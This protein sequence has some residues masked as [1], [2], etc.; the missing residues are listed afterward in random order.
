MAIVRCLLL[1]A[2]WL[3]AAAVPAAGQQ[4]VDYASVSGR[5]TDPSGAVV[6]GARVTA[7]HLGTNIVSE[8][9]TDATGRFRFPHLRIGRCDITVH[10]PGFADAVRALTLTAG[11]AFELPLTLTVGGLDASVTVSREA[12]VLDS[13]RSQ[14][15]GTISQ[16]EVRALPLDGRNFLDLAL[17]VPGAAPANV[18]ATQLF[19]E[20]SAVPGT[21]LSIGGQRNLSTSFIVDGMSANDD[22]AALSGIPYSVDAIE[23]L[24]VVTSGGQA[25]L[26]RALGGYVS[27]VTRSGSNTLTGDVYGYARDERLNARNALSGSR[28]PMRQVQYG[29]SLGGPLVASRTFY[30]TNVERRQLDQ[31][32]L[33]TIAPA[34]AAAINARLQAVGYAGPRVT[35]GPYQTPVRSTMLLGKLDHQA[36][37]RDQ[38]TVR[39]ALYDVTSRN[40]RGAGGLSAPSA[41]A[42]LD[43]RDDAVAL[44]NTVMLTSR[45]VLESRAQIARGDLRAP[46][47]DPIGPAVAIAGVASFGT[48]SNSPTR[49][50]NSMYQIVNNVSHQAGAHALRTGLDLLYNADRID[51]P[52]AARGSYTFASLPAFLAGSYNN[53]GF[54]QTFGV[55][56][57]AQ[58][59]PNVGLFAQD[60]WKAGRRLTLNLGLRYDLQF[61]QTI[62][63][64]RNNLSPRVGAVWAPSASRRTLI[65]GSA[66]LFY[67]RVPLRPL[68]NAL[69]S[70]G[71]TTDLGS[72]RQIGVSL[73]AAQPGA[74]AFPAILSRTV[75]SGARVN[76]TTMDRGLR[77]AY[78]RQ[79]SVE[80]EQ[81]VGDAGAVSAGY[82]YLRGEGLLMSINQNV[83]TCAAAG[84]NNG[85]RPVSAYANNNRYSSAGSSASHALQVSWRQR[86]ARWGQYRVSYVLAKSMNNVG[87]FFFSSP[88]DPLDLSKDWGRSD[89]D[90]RHRLVVNGALNTPADVRTPLLRGFQL[91]GVLQA[92]SA[93][94]FNITSGLTTVQGTTGRPVVNGAFIPRNA[95]RGSG[96]ATLNARVSREFRLASRVAVQ[97]LLEG[98]NLTNRRNVLG[99]NANF[100]SGAYPAQPS[101]SFGQ[102]TAVGEPRAFQ[103]GVRIRFQ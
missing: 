80:V 29:G 3:A 50:T 13:A 72:L 20:T 54:A 94:P 63:A 32:G 25:E 83:A 18:G 48:L 100:G 92:Y 43:N 86:P 27:V 88:V 2:V 62:S 95:G 52:R 28:L 82:R 41:A 84:D 31:T 37:S 77:S 49:R 5:V 44:G 56:Q 102:I 65:R 11:A 97:G 23:E 69:L 73:S 60:E 53:A 51:F 6:A 33:V 17:L 35:T 12:T 64:D 55:S 9:L 39:Y 38:L 26:G 24:Q 58:T 103:L 57:V 42:D 1:L 74:P 19:P 76:L 4:S 8:A 99:R 21:S 16:A 36:G 68:A 78:S 70:A 87:E 14:I 40:A 91:S 96:F 10:Q 85:C 75:A 34:S 7:R 93:L 98:F 79:A 66:G 67:D 61:L 101:G 71:N 59:S 90:Q 81:Q 15:A 89:D 46:P 30:F 22:A 47:A 45:T